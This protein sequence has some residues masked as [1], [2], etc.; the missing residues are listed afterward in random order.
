MD[1]ESF[2][3]LDIVEQVE[4]INSKTITGLKV[5]EVA[6]EIGIG[7]KTLRERLKKYRYAFNRADKVY[8]LD[9]IIE[10]KEGITTERKIPVNEVIPKESPNG[11]NEVIRVEEKK[12]SFSA[13]E[14]KELKEL[15]VIKESLLKLAITPSNKNTITIMDKSNRKK[16]TFNMDIELIQELEQHEKTLINIS[17]SDIVN[18]ALR[19]YLNNS[20]ITKK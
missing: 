11:N 17:K 9:G 18:Q 12:S 14:I 2:L 16:A 19:E 10:H 20:G 6:Q 5:S 7:D 3:K 1:K 4:F 15:L 13:K 8:L